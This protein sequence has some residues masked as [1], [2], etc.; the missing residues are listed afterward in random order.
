MDHQEGF[1]KSGTQ[2]VLVFNSVKH[3]V[4]MRWW[5]RDEGGKDI[6]NKLASLCKAP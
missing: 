3:K 6:L 1:L 5:C 4:L 2:I